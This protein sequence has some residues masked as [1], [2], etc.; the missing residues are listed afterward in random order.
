MFTVGNFIK[1]LIALSLSGGSNFIPILGD[2]GEIAGGG[3]GGA[4][5]AFVIRLIIF[6]FLIGKVF[7]FVSFTFGGGLGRYSTTKIYRRV[8]RY[9]FILMLTPPFWVAATLIF[10]ATPWSEHSTQYLKN[11]SRIEQERRNLA[12]KDRQRLISDAK[13][14]LKRDRSNW[15]LRRRVAI[16]EAKKSRQSRI[17]KKIESLRNEVLEQYKPQFAKLAS[18]KQFLFKEP[19]ERLSFYLKEDYDSSNLVVDIKFIVKRLVDASKLGIDQKTQDEFLKEFF[20]PLFLSHLL[21]KKCI[22]DFYLI[23]IKDDFLKKFE[24]KH[25]ILYLMIAVNSVKDDEFLALSNPYLR[26]SDTVKFEKD[27]LFAIGFW[28]DLSKFRSRELELKQQRDRKLK[29]IRYTEPPIKEND[30]AIVASVGTFPPDVDEASFTLFVDQSPIQAN[31]PYLEKISPT[32]EKHWWW[33]LVAGF[34]VWLWVLDESKEF[35]SKIY[36]KIARVILYEGRF[37]FGGSARFANMFEEWGSAYKKNT[38]YVGCSLSSRSA[39]IGLA[40]EAHMITVA[41]SRGG[42]GAT[43]IIPNLLLWEGSAVVIDP[44]GTNARVTAEARRRMGH[45][46]YLIDPFGIV[47]KDSDRFDPLEGLDPDD[48]LVRERIATIVDALV[49]PD[50]NAKDKHWD[51]GAKTIL[52]GLISQL[53]SSDVET[54]SLFDIRDLISQLPEDQDALWEAMA[55]NDS[56]GGSAKDA[57][58]RYIRGSHTNEILS[59][60]SN[61]DKHTEWLSSPIMRHITSNPTFKLSD[62]K[63]TR[64][65]IYI[66]VPPLQLERQNRLMRLFINLMIDVM[67]RGGRSKIPV[68]MLMDE[69]L[70]LGKMPEIPSAF[71]TMASY[72]L[73]LW[74]FVQD[75]GQM[76]ELYGEGFNSFIANSRAMQVFAVSDKKTREF[77]SETIGNRPLGSLTDIV[78][79]S[80]NVPLRSPDDV[81]VDVGAG[82]GRQY[83]IRPGKAPMILEKVPYFKKGTRFAGKYDPDPDFAR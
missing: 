82:D 78:R 56:A 62:V 41:G 46:V 44:K 57:A 45:D 36:S 59:L 39:E 23:E 2:L 34:I 3:T 31:D 71:A 72:N 27:L 74:P 69:F 38:L 4:I 68:L 35:I 7:D 47:T 55:S 43:A 10:T 76:Q 17:D 18:E 40:G 5:I 64:T 83:I 26:H 63:K 75:L 65:T 49:V 14:K 61:A 80:E 54:K 33:L 70:A 30:P 58:M 51:A 66:I 22:D 19:N 24:D 50:E 9:T 32:F 16:G 28:G 37:G 29:A 60:M 77:V 12:E 11:V 13:I 79:S 6:W 81:V 1:L 73:T 25:C 48:I 42:K 8:Q 52:S 53:I 20:N 21:N 67:E 15:E